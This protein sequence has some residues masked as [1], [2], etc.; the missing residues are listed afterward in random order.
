MTQQ[1]EKN[2]RSDDTS[3][4]DLYKRASILEGLEYQ[5]RLRAHAAPIWLDENSFW[6]VREILDGRE[7]RHV[8]VRERTNELAFD[9]I[10]LADALSI[11][12]GDQVQSNELS[13]SRLEISKGTLR[14]TAYGRNWK[15]DSK[16]TDE[17]QYEPDPSHWLISSDRTQAAYVKDH[18]LWVCDVSAGRERAVTKDGELHYAYAIEPEGRHLIDGLKGLPKQTGKPLARPEAAWSPNGKLIFTF[19]LDEREVGIMPTIAFAPQDGSL[20]PIGVDC[21]YAL[22]GDKHVPTY[23]FVILS[24]ETGKEIQVDYPPLEDSFIWFSFFSGN[25]AWWS[26][27]GAKAYFLDMERGQKS[28]RV[29]EVDAST[30][31]TRVL[32]EERAETYLEIGHDFETPTSIIPIP[33]TDELIWFSQRTG[34]AHLYLYDLKNGELKNAITSGDWSVSEAFDFDPNRREVYIQTFG[35]EPGRNYYFRDVVR[36]HIDTG[37]LSPL[38]SGNFNVEVSMQL[39]GKAGLSPCKNYIV[40][41]NSRIDTPASL[42]LRDRSGEV[43]LELETSDL[44]MLPDFW[45]WPEEFKCLGADGKT[46]IF[47]AI[48]KP[49]DFDPN[50]KYPV[51]DFTHVSAYFG[52][53]PRT[54]FASYLCGMSALAELGLIVVNMNGRG[55]GCRDKEFRD[56]GYNDFLEQG[57][58]LDHV[59]AIKHLAEDRD[60]MDLNR[61]GMLDFDGSNAALFALLKFPEFF[62]VGICGSV[63]DP[64]LIKQGEVYSGITT[65]DKRNTLEVWNTAVESL[66]GKLLIQT[67]LLDKYYHPSATFHLTDAL[68]KAN[69]DFEHQVHP[70]G[71]HG[72]RLITSRRRIWDF[73]VKNLIGETPPKEFELLSG[74]EQADAR[75]NAGQITEI[76]KPDSG[77]RI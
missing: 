16:L 15:F 10:A 55:T 35:R 11:A 64:R 22:P 45:R 41:A 6:Y 17:G 1:H 44:S 40:T 57:G 28:V 30:G 61:V 34:H 31:R 33:E 66:Q 42:E 46:P 20:R 7:Y 48:F 54:A 77:N 9:H 24:V 14:F 27:D 53:G 19:Q 39:I 8:R 2:F 29:V 56:Y 3:I 50:R 62:S 52:G 74:S 75:I 51:L 67:G 69:K 63:Y 23:R 12:T 38:V 72:W 76:Q 32:F 68:I 58:I 43:V 4:L 25:R 60:Y 73:L 70:N 65:E 37:D 36:V 18:N 49:S 71:A 5:P 21:R 26:G 47:G 59:A 13:L